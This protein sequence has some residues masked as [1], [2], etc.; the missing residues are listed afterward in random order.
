MSWLMSACD[1]VIHQRE[2]KLSRGSVRLWHMETQQQLVL[3]DQ[4]LSATSKNSVSAV[5]CH[6]IACAPP[7]KDYC[8]LN[9]C[10]KYTQFVYSPCKCLGCRIFKPH[11]CIVIISLVKEFHAII[12]N[13]CLWTELHYMVQCVSRYSA[14]K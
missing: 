5:D 13:L 7:R 2:M 4:S 10:P 11:D 14:Y 9:H 6:G 3:L 8:C 1:L 12:S